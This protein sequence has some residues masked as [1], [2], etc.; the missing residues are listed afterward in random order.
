[1][2]ASLV[3]SVAAGGRAYFVAALRELF[4]EAGLL[5][6]R[7][8]AGAAPEFDPATTRRLAAARAALNAGQCS[9]SDVLAR[10]GLWLDLSAL[11]YL[12]HWVT[13]EGPPRRFDTRFFVV[14]APAHQRAAHDEGETVAAVWIRPGDAL[15]AQQRGEYEMIFPTIRTLQS[16]AGFVT[17]AEVLSFARAQTS[18]TRIQPRIVEREGSFAI[19]LPGDEGY[20]D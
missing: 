1:V 4:E 18:V 7:N 15:A 12:A 2:D 13:P 16:V 14:E 17:A 11:A 3:L 5:I 20:G 19:L 6:S 10:E 9:L 8:D